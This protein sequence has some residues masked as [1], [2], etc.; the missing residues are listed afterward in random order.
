MT[1][2]RDK[3][4]V[5]AP[6]TSLLQD[7]VVLAQAW[8]KAHTYVRRHNWYA[9]TLELD[10]SAFDLDTKLG[11]WSNELKKGSYR[12]NAAW[13][14][15]APKNGAWGFGDRFPGGWGARPAEDDSRPVLRPLAH[16]GIR[17]QTVATAA[18]L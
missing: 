8:K 1:I 10:C 15:P 14:V 18:M 2:V 9:D 5:L 3:F 12:P 16:L 7:V 4:R 13:L 11:Q 6:R 17:E